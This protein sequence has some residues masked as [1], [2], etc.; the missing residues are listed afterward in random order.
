MFNVAVGHGLKHFV[1]QP[2]AEKCSKI[3][4]QFT[5][6]QQKQRSACISSPEKHSKIT[7]PS[8]AG[9]RGTASTSSH[10]SQEEKN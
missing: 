8:T 10:T 9:Q 6:G 5:A 7:K 4:K 1:L 3:T 2:S